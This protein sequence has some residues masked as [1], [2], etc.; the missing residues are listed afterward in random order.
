MNEK[1]KQL[2]ID[3]QVHMVSEERLED[4]A[5]RIIYECM[6]VCEDVALEMSGVAK[7]ELVTEAGRDI[8][9]AMGMGARNCATYIHTEFF[10]DREVCD[11]EDH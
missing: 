9:V 10:G 4:F 1:I 6:Y 5:K 11:C 2:A 7:G 3:A 8:H